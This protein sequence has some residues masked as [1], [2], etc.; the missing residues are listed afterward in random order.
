[1]KHSRIPEPYDPVLM[2]HLSD[3][4]FNRR[5]YYLTIGLYVLLGASASMMFIKLLGF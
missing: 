1:M 2:Y 4:D 5:T 3:R